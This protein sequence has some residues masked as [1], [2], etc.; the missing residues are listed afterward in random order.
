MSAP[1]F[2]RSAPACCLCVH[3]TRQRLC[4]H[5]T[6]PIDP[7]EG[8]PNVPCRVMRGTKASC[9]PGLALCGPAGTLFTKRREGVPA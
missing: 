4:D 9:L 2:S 5:P 1:H 3:A 7:V 6:T 8:G